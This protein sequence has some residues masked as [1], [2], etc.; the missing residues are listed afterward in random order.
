MK[1]RRVRHAVMAAAAALLLTFVAIQPVAAASDFYA[2]KVFRIV[3][4][5]G[6][7]GGYDLYA[8]LLARHLARHVP[9]NPT[10]IVDHMPGA[11]GQRAA[12]WLYTVAPKDGTVIGTLP[13]ELPHQ[14]LLRDEGARF[15]TAKFNW[16]GTLADLHQVLTLYGPVSP[17]KTLEDAKKAEVLLGGSGHGDYFHILPLAVNTLVGTRFRVVLGYRGANDIDLAME[18]GEV[19][20]RS[21]SWAQYK[22]SRGSWISEK[23]LIVLAQ[24]G[25][26]RH[27]DLP[28]VPLLTELVAS[29]DDRKIMDFITSP[30]LLG[31]AFCLPPDVPAERVA[32]LR[33]AFDA[34][35]ADPVFLTD[36]RERN[37]ELSPIRGAELDGLIKEALAIPTPLVERVKEVLKKP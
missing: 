19:H 1:L 2:G 17:A 20:G 27:V 25:R 31:R 12:N 9:G 29:G 37:I 23:K 13:A 34:L 30:V 36:A 18:K 33:A 24:A 28:D 15:D 14:Q 21:G 8:Q 4:S 10:I 16:I 26:A 3:V 7:G 6:A 11:G 32:T 35:I 22:V 5:Y